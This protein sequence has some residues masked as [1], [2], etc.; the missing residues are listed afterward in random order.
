MITDPESYFS[1]GCGRCARFGT[2]DCATQIWGAGLLALRRIC[3]SMVLEETAKWGHPCY[4]FA[5]RNIAI[6]GA[7]RGEFRLTF[8]NA[9]LL[10]DPDRVLEHKGPN[11]RQADTI[12]FTDPSL[13]P[14][15]EGAIRALLQA[16]MDAAA[17]GLKPR[18]VIA[19]IDLPEELIEVLASDPD[20]SE[21]FDALTP[22]RQRSYAINLNGAK[23]PQ[24]R[25]RRIESFRDKIIAGKGATER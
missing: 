2:A 25:Y 7:F 11:S 8:F 22:G 18:K 24:T 15:R 3:L 16:A 5:G 21:A 10:S 17:A 6:I 4:M 12:S 9:S 23:T 19:P 14:S 1:Q 13:L 20:L